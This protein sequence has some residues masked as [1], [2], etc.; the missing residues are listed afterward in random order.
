[1]AALSAN[2]LVWSAISRMVSTMPEIAVE[3]C[4][5]LGRLL[6]RTRD[7][8]D[9][10]GGLV[11]DAGAGRGVLARR[12]GDARGVFGVAG[13]VGDAGRHVGHRLGRG[14]GGFV[15]A[16]RTVGRLLGTADQLVGS[17]GH[18]ARVEDDARDDAAEAADE[19]VVGDRRGGDA[20][21]FPRFDAPCQV[22]VIARRR[23]SRA[24]DLKRPRDRPGDVP[25]RHHRHQQ[26]GNDEECDQAGAGTAA[27]NI[28]A[29]D[30]G[31][32]DGQ[33]GKRLD[34]A[35]AKAAAGHVPSP[36]SRRTGNEYPPGAPRRRHDARAQS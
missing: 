23:D 19:V 8:L 24:Q 2:R 25:A 29:T 28:G 7:A 27:G 22:A 21:A 11:D 36:R 35:D 32:R 12:L 34:G 31:G 16:L 6:D 18:L 1:M 30:T 26:A 17:V 33:T 4:H 10:L 20:A 15:L 13:D 5:H 3:R 14:F 9:L